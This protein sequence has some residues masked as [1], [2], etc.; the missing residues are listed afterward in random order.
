MEGIELT[1]LQ[2]ISAV[3]NARS[4]YIEAMQEAR[5]GNIEKAQELLQEGRESFTEGHQAHAGIL[6]QEAS[7]D[8]I[9]VRLLLMH[10]EDQ[11][12][13]AEGFGIMAREY[14]ELAKVLKEKNC[15]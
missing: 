6:S 4:F 13:S 9:E 7:G 8:P 5:Q 12:M 14:I 10:A 15:L 1:A 2:I 11:L 3:G